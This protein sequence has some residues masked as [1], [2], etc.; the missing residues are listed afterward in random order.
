MISRYGSEETHPCAFSK[1][2]Y[3][4]DVNKLGN[5]SYIK[6][7]ERREI[8]SASKSKLR[9]EKSSTIEK[10]EGDSKFNDRNRTRSNFSPSGANLLNVKKPKDLEEAQRKKYDFSP[11]S[12]L[13]ILSRKH[14][15]T[16]KT[17]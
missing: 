1:P 16:L 13:K 12:N 6:S 4:L 17:S 3:F 2:G 11:S 15:K 8:C 7:K 14:D 9:V 5:S 10:N